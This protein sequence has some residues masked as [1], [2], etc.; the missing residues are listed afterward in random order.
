MNLYLLSQSEETH[1][2]SYNFC[3]VAAKSEAEAQKIHPSGNNERWG[4]QSWA[5]TPKNVEVELLGKAIENIE[6]GVVCASTQDW[7]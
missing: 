3:V 1:Y 4:N 7:L 5:S 2:D 6:S